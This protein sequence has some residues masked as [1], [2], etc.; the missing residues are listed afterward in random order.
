MFLLRD[1]GLESW[2]DLPKP[3]T[4]KP[5][6]PSLVVLQLVTFPSQTLPLRMG[7]NPGVNTIKSPWDL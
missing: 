5:V 7:W 6:N 4:G 1:Q 2:S 3:A